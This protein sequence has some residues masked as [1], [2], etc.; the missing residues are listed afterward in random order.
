VGSGIAVDGFGNVYVTGITRSTNF[1]TTPGAFQTTY[2]ID[3]DAFVTKLNPTEA[4][5][6][7]STYL[8]GNA[9]VVGGDPQG[10][11]AGFG[12]AVDGNGNAYVTGGTTSGNFP[13][14]PGA[15]QITFGGGF[16]AF[17]TKLN[18]AG[19]ALVYSTY[20][21]GS[22]T[23][24]GLSI[25]V[26]GLDN[27]YVT[28]SAC[29]NFPTTPGAFQ[30][31]CNSFDAF[32]TKL[33]PTGSG[34]SYSTYLGGGQDQG[35]GIAVDGLGNAYVTGFTYSDFF[36]FPTTPGAFQTTSGGLG[37]T[38]VAKI[39]FNNSPVCGAA[40]ANPAS[41]WK[42][43]GLLVPIAITGVTDPDGNPLT[44]T[45]TRVTQDEPVVSRGP[46][47]KLDLRGSQWVFFCPPR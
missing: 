43:D 36:N 25:A 7:Y 12:I 13:T 19:T 40:L 27:A 34:L 39:S 3:Y 2:G 18:A 21:G 11:D 29:G 1:P 33:N 47:K 5:L 26:D 45:V 22:D 32:I 35:W 46:N 10:Y 4:G 28:G 31:T 6:A 30:T 23:D 24:Q 17:V 15:F 8:G 16:D 37:D 44:I 9:A 42:P 20:L 14:T 41:L 38:F